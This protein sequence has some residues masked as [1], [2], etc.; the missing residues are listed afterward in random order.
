MIVDFTYGYVVYCALSR[1]NTVPVP[2]AATS[3][4]SYAAS[5]MYL[6]YTTDIQ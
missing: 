3:P 5:E 2:N 4:Y 1:G 6:I